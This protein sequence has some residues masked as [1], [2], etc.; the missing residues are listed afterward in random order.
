MNVSSD[1]R[2]KLP[3]KRLASRLSM[4][5]FRPKDR[6]P[7]LIIRQSLSKGNER[8][9]CQ[10][11]QHAREDYSITTVFVARTEGLPEWR[12]LLGDYSRSFHRIGLP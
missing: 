6:L 2:W 12:E 8:A 7:Y 11:E 5:R 9:G 10:P 4:S 3:W 1:Q